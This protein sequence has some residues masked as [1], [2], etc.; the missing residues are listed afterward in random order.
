MSDDGAILPQGS[1][2][3]VVIRGPDMTPGYASNPDANAR[4]FTDGWFR[5][6]AQPEKRIL[7]RNLPARWS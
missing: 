6:G 3:E 4:A 1:I 7:H 5:T 2:G